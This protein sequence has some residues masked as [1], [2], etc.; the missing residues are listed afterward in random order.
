MGYDWSK[1]K[2]Y[3]HFV[4]QPQAYGYV[5][6]YHE[7]TYN[8]YSILLLPGTQLL[9][10]WYLGA[11][12]LIGLSYIFLG[13]AIVSANLLLVRVGVYDAETI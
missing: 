11:A 4:L 2:K 8:C 12:Y 7:D 1:A 6:Y 13:V 5:E 10:K 3:D 9:N